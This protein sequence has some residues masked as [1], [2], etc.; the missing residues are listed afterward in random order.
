MEGWVDNYH[1]YTCMHEHVWG[2]SGQE[3]GGGGGYASP[4]SSSFLLQT[5]RV[6]ESTQLK[7]VW[8]YERSNWQGL[9]EVLIDPQVYE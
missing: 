9:E 8:V 1:A 5:C 2:R 4:L 3:G 7:E 6:D